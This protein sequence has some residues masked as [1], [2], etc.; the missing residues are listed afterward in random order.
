MW[1]AQRG[2]QRGLQSGNSSS[3]LENVTSHDFYF[4][5]CIYFSYDFLFLLFSV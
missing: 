4:F 1:G 5:L 3:A 2:G